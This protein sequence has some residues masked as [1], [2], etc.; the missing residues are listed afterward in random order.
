MELERAVRKIAKLESLQWNYTV[1]NSAHFLTLFTT[2]QVLYFSYCTFHTHVSSNKDGEFGGTFLFLGNISNFDRGHF[3]KEKFH[4]IWNLWDEVLEELGQ[5][6]A[7]TH[8]RS[9][10]RPSSGYFGNKGSLHEVH[11]LKS[12]LDGDFLV[13]TWSIVWSIATWSGANWSSIGRAVLNV[14]LW[15][16][17]I[18][19][20]NSYRFVQMTTG[21]FSIKLSIISWHRDRN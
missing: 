2:F 16:D 13:I 1:L 3:G 6:W 20:L 7:D 18:F 17:V 10:V 14:I 5:R 8:V 4:R 12:F 11:I 15:F 21:T 9:S 19:I